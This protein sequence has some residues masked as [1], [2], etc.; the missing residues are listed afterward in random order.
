MNLF[1]R[2]LPLAFALSAVYTAIIASANH[3]PDV[4]FPKANGINRFNI[5]FMPHLLLPTGLRFR[6]MAIFLLCLS[7]LSAV[8]APRRP[9]LSPPPPNYSAQP[10]FS[11][12]LNP[13]FRYKRSGQT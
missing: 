1:L 10:G 12:L 6:A 5:L 11:R 4:D 2:L 13:E 9:R 7:V 3:K 8:L